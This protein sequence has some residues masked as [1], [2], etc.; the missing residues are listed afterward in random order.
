MS[1]SDEAAYDIANAA[2]DRIEQHEKLCGERYAQI[3]SNQNI[4]S[5]DR[6]ILREL[7]SD[8]FEKLYGF[9]W[10]ITFSF[11]GLLVGA[12][13]TMILWLINNT[14]FWQKPY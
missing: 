12:L 14:V 8:K 4:G 9:L 1:P 5:Q 6:T 11:I 7:M 13:G 3:V 10:K 2:M